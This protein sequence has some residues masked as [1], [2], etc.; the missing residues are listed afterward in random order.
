MSWGY[1]RVYAPHRGKSNIY[2]YEHILVAEEKIG[3]LLNNE[4]VHHINGNKIDNRSDN[5]LVLTPSQHRTLHRQL[6]ELAMEL[7]VKGIIIY[8]DGVYMWADNVDNG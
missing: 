3:R 2:S 6:E 7:V 1:K 5:L 8:K 4:H